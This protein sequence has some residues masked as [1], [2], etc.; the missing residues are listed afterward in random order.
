MDEVMITFQR[1]PDVNVDLRVPVFVT[2]EEL[3][4]LISEALG[5]AISSDNRL[6]AEPLGR[7]LDNHQ[8]LEQEGVMHGALLTLI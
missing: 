8:T 2:V 1:Q 5:L 3:L 4:H 7:I 6:Q